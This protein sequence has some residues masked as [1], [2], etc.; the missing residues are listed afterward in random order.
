MPLAVAVLTGKLA[1]GL[2]PAMGALSAVAADQAGSY[3]ARVVR[4]GVVA[5]AGAIG[6][7]I[8]GN[9]R[10]DGWWTVIAVTLLAI[11]AAL[12]SGTGG[13]GSI[14]GLNLMI[15]TI[16]AT[17]MPIAGPPAKNAVMFLAG[18]LWVMVLLGVV[19]PLRPTAPERE[20]VAGVYM[21][22]A[23]LLREPG[24]AARDAYSTARRS[25]Y[26]QVLAAR[27]SAPGPQR[28][29]TRLVALLNQASLIRDAAL[30][31][32]LEGID[33]LPKA[34]A[35]AER[36]AEAVLG[37]RHDMAEPALTGHSPSV[38]ALR[39]TLAGAVDIVDPTSSG[40]EPPSFTGR[41]RPSPRALL[42]A[43]T[44][45]RL[46][47]V[48]A[49]RLALCMAVAGTLSELDT[50]QRS[51]WVMLTVAVVLKPDFGSVFARAVQRGIG[52]MVG[53]V[54]GA[55]L[56]ALSHD[57]PW[58]L[59]PIA[60]LSFGLPY[61]K[62]RN[63]GL[64]STIQA[65]LVIFFID[66]PADIGW[67]LAEIR[68]VDTLAG[69]LIVL[70]V[71]YLPWP[72][73]WH[74]PVAPRLAEALDAV[75]VYLRCAFTAATSG[76]SPGLPQ[77]KLRQEAYDRMADL[78]ASFQR[79]VAEPPAVSR[80]VTAWWPAVVAVQRALDV[81]AATTARIRHGAVP[82]A[83]TSVEDLA[84]ALTRMADD[85]RASS[86][87]RPVEAPGDEA[88]APVTAAVVGIHAML[89]GSADRSE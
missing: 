64:F 31:L 26:Q 84:R 20:A 19:W 42:A 56:L 8:G 81:I 69:C 46:I 66:L 76:D 50:L 67:R 4:F 2:L 82:P 15:T 6:F 39:T 80:R 28:E 14:V 30:S 75:A 22:L 21:A 34:A 51:Y 52:T 72:G 65:P 1:D 87:P 85:I 78:R 55:A 29:R 23:R 89:S 32:G 68:L 86:P 49:L 3:R 48:Y 88:L 38:V 16:V 40:D 54:A 24:T 61:G 83:A 71:G 53:A 13:T 45:G 73:A 79:A 57:G 77:A 25:A 5:V 11:V 12:L 41:P 18:A 63:W 35:V 58:L 37:E 74:A 17:G 60:A 33:S 10:G 7:L 36:I 27:S 43:A 9:V 44:S 47:R 70:V 62:Q 59:V